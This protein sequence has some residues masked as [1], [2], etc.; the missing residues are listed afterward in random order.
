SKVTTV[1]ESTAAE[2][3]E[4]MDQISLQRLE[5]VFFQRNQKTKSA[6]RVA[7]DVL[8]DN[9][10]LPV[11]DDSVIIFDIPFRL[12]IKGYAF[13]SRLAEDKDGNSIFSCIRISAHDLVGGLLRSGFTEHQ[14]Y[15]FIELTTFGR[16]VEDLF[17]A[18]LLRVKNGSYIFFAPAYHSPVL[19][20]IALSR[21]AW[22]NRRRDE[23]GENANGNIFEGKGKAFESRVLKD[24]IDAGLS[25]KTFKYSLDKAEYECDVAVLIDKVLFVFECKNRSLPMGHIPSIYYFIL[26]LEAAKD[27]VTRIAQQLDEYPEIISREFGPNAKWKRIVPVVLHALPW[28]SGKSDGVYFYDGSALSHLIHTGFTSIITEYKLDAQKIQRRHRY[29]LRKGEIP[30]SEELERDMENPTQLR[31]HSLGWKQESTLN[32]VSNDLVFALPQWTQRT[33][34]IEEQMVALGSSQ[35]EANN[36]ANEMRE[37]IPKEIRSVQIKKITGLH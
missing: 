11:D 1:L 32:Q 19:G 16:G 5:Q 33:I 14:S 9:Y 3:V 24:F 6:E 34:N 20:V 22:L 7:F 37:E 4:L 31:L 23:Y 30:T 35:E 26:G 12:W 29:Q 8:R 36:I 2:K 28:S 15:K 13:Y 10:H 17:D 18:P 25:A 21:I 27:Q